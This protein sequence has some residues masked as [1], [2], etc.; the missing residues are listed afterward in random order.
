MTFAT[1]P[2]QRIRKRRLR[3][4][5]VKRSPF[6]M[7]SFKANAAGRT[8]GE[9]HFGHLTSQLQWCSL[10]RYQHDFG[11]VIRHNARESRV[12]FDHLRGECTRGSL[13]RF[14]HDI[15]RLVL[16]GMHE[17]SYTNFMEPTANGICYDFC[18]GACPRQGKCPWTHNLVEIAWN[19]AKQPLPD[20]EKI[21]MCVT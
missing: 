18:R 20:I 5:D 16:Q 3:Q 9:A 12:C 1:V 8:A 4:R 6:A 14:S 19:T 15:Q 21:N 10:I 17:A 7:T 2:R 13:C 11:A